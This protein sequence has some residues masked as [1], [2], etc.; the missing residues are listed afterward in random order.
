MTYISTHL[1][2]IY[3]KKY[4]HDKFNHI[5]TVLRH[6]P[7]QFLC[8]VLKHDKP[9][10]HHSRS[11]CAVL[12]YDNPGI[13]TVDLFVMWRECGKRKASAQCL[14]VLCWKTACQHLKMP[15]YWREVSLLSL[16]TL[17]VS[18]LAEGRN[19]STIV[20]TEIVL[21]EKSFF[22]NNPYGDSSMGE[23]FLHQ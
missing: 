11:L 17:L 16:H 15:F 10:A 9:R 18:K 13:I 3:L 7:S 12:K 4:V 2:T 19:S 21:L 14:Y 23:K 22:T 20:P 8:A 5:F 6:N 1:Y